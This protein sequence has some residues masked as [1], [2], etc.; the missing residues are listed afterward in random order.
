MLHVSNFD[1]FRK[2][3]ART[4]IVQRPS[5]NLSRIGKIK[6]IN[7]NRNSGTA[8]NRS[9][10]SARSNKLEIER[11]FDTRARNISGSAYSTNLNTLTQQQQQQ[12][13]N[14]R[15]NPSSPNLI[16]TNK[17]KSRKEIIK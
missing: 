4:S 8:S 13:N 5:T 6:F 9:F 10:F 7:S 12:Q 11:S 15:S 3:G 2:S 1:E 14:S 17:N 16:S